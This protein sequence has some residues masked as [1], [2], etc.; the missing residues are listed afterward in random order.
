[1]RLIPQKVDDSILHPLG[2]NGPRTPISLPVPHHV[3]GNQAEKLGLED[4]VHIP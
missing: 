3:Y 1:M 2:V 4:K